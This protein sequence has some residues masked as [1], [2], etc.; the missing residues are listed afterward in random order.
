MVLVL[1]AALEFVP[2]YSGAL[3]APVFAAAAIVPFVLVR[4][5][6][7]SR[8]GAVPA[9][10]LAVVV[11]LAGA[12]WALLGADDS[13]GLAAFTDA[14]PR[15]LTTA[16]PAPVD[17]ALL[18]P[19]ALLVALVATVVA[20]CV[21]APPP[22]VSAK[23]G[24]VLAPMLGASVLYVAAQLLD[25]GKADRHGIVAVSLL[26]VTVVSWSTPY[27]HGDDRVSMSWTPAVIA[28][29]IGVVAL[30]LAAAAVVPATGAFE[31]RDHVTPPT[32]SLTEASPL[33]L[34]AAWGRNQGVEIL[35]ANVL[36]TQRLRLAT[37]STFSG[38]AWQVDDSYTDFAAVGARDL[39]H[40]GRVQPVTA[41]VSITQL[42][43]LWV[44]TPGGTSATSLA[45]AVVD[46]D[47]G[48][49][50]R[51]EPV[52]AGLTYS[53]AGELDAPTQDTLRTAG[54]ATGVP[55]RYLAVPHL[56][57]GLSQYARDSV[58]GASSPLEE[59]VALE[60]AVTTGRR[61]VP[62]APTGSSYARLT[63]F[64]FGAANRAGAQ[65]GSS[66]QFATAFAVLARAVGLP[67]RVVVGFI[68]PKAAAGSASVVRGVNAEAWPEVYL[69]GAGWVPFEPTPGSGGSSGDQGLKQAVLKRLKNNQGVV[70]APSRQPRPPQRTPGT[71]PSASSGSAHSAFSA[72]LLLMIL[73]L[74]V[75]VIVLLL[76]ALRWARTAR[77]RRSGAPGAWA[78]VLDL[79][80]LMGR[81]APRHVA[82]PELALDLD[83]RL[84]QPGG[85]WLVADAADRAAFA[86]DPA[87][88]GGADVW[89][90]VRVLKRRAR[91]QVRWYRRAGF[92]VDPRPLLRRR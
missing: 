21:F 12:W 26:L 61:L 5:G 45:G 89:R 67:S 79:L 48:G 85:A 87:A 65:V 36:G 38:D 66:E 13:T 50:A 15:L 32:V 7:A 6:A 30:G 59:A 57:G 23:V 82:A 86:P 43:G 31:P 44:P 2:S 40:A 81:P 1:I 69:A 53:V 41:D 72:L 4:L 39:P 20:V 46:R 16:R 10:A 14:V 9:A 3:P 73:A 84:G 90:Q 37:L 55:K 88:P 29:A 78:E 52:T 25:A 54:L 47:N 76:A 34:L 24:G 83:R 35:K 27:R 63:T 92:G 75:L 91:S 80:V 74:L 28:P 62:T 77:H 22:D 18:A 64:L 68:V 33:T 56:P 42:G 49:L 11:A 71:V 17:A 70:T 60:N 8:L 51:P 19:P 58:R